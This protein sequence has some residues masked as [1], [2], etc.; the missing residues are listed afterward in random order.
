MKI[1]IQFPIVRMF[2][3]Y[4][5]IEYYASILS[6]ATGVK[7]RGNEETFDQSTGMYIGSFCVG[8]RNNEEIVKLVKEKYGNR[9]VRIHD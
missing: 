2:S 9:T 6:D 4:H 1:E 3:D 5:D 7:V 8:D